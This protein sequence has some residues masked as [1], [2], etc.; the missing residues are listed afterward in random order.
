MVERRYW[1][2]DIETMPPAALRQLENEYLQT[3]LDYVWA[4]SAFY[5]AGS[6]RLA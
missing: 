2:E 5:Q 3:Q 4:R 6:L 1:D